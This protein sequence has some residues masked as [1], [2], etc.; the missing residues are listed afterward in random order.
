[1]LGYLVDSSG[2][3]VELLG[4]FL[5]FAA[6]N[7]GVFE[8]RD[9]IGQPLLSFVQGNEL[10]RVLPD[11]LA[12]PDRKK[13]VRLHRNDAPERLRLWQLSVESTGSATRVWFEQLAQK[14]R[15]FSAQHIFSSPVCWCS[16]C[17]AVQDQQGSYVWLNVIDS[18]RLAGLVCHYPE[19]IR[20]VLCSSCL[21]SLQQPD[22]PGAFGHL[23]RAF[24]GRAERPLRPPVSSQTVAGDLFLR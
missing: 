6:R 19:S 10:K 24:S 5:G 17:N 11:L 12:D 15:P 4:D 23:L 16:W 9:I 18:F 21:S 13:K 14:D 7:G 2:C 22:R 1:M 3:V 8:R 20:H